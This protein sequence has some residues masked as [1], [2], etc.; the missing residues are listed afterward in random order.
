MCAK[1]CESVTIHFISPKSSAFQLYCSPLGMLLSKT[2]SYR[3]HHPN[4]TQD[5][6]TAPLS[7][8]ENAYAVVIVKTVECSH[9]DADNQKA[10][11]IIGSKKESR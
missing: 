9:Q 8:T 6:E 2:H 1:V 7:I 5:R 4:K 10:A 3:A 11:T